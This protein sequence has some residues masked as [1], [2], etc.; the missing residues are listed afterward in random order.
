MTPLR[1]KVWIVMLTRNYDM[2]TEDLMKGKDSGGLCVYDL[3]WF[4]WLETEGLV[5]FWFR[6]QWNHGAKCVWYHGCVHFSMHVSN[7]FKDWGNF[8]WLLIHCVTVLTHLQEIWIFFYY[9]RFHRSVCCW[10]LFLF[11]FYFTLDIK[12][13]PN[14]EPK[15]FNLQK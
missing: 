2:M 5:C 14:A 11:I 7:N 4:S 15:F 13:S 10:S 1:L 9:I 8:P 12:R 3:C 6:A